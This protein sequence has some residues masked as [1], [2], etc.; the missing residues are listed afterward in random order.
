MPELGS[1]AGKNIPKVFAPI[2]PISKAFHRLPQTLSKEA[3]GILDDLLLNPFAKDITEK[4]SR[5]I[6]LTGDSETSTPFDNARWALGNSDSLMA[7]PVLQDYTKQVKNLSPPPKAH[8]ELDRKMSLALDTAMHTDDLNEA[9]DAFVKWA[10]YMQSV[11]QGDSDFFS[12]RRELFTERLYGALIGDK[13]KQL[14]KLYEEMDKIQYASGRNDRYFVDVAG[15]QK[16][17]LEEIVENRLSQSFIDD[18][19]ELESDFLISLTN[20]GLRKQEV[21][22]SRHRFGKM[23]DIEKAAFRKRASRIFKD[24]EEVLASNPNPFERLLLVSLYKLHSTNPHVTKPD[25]E[26]HIRGL[27]KNYYVSVILKYQENS[28]QIKAIIRDESDPWKREVLQAVERKLGLSGF[29]TNLDS[30]LAAKGVS[31]KYQKMLEKIDDELAKPLVSANV[32]DKMD[33]LSKDAVLAQIFDFEVLAYKW[34]RTVPIRSLVLPAKNSPQFQNILSF[35]RQWP[36][37]A[38]DLG[39]SDSDT[40]LIQSQFEKILKLGY[41]KWTFLSSS[42]PYQPLTPL[43]WSLSNSY[44]PKS[45]SLLRRFVSAPPFGINKG[46]LEAVEDLLGQRIIW[47]ALQSPQNEKIFNE[48]AVWALHVQSLGEPEK[49]IALLINFI[50]SL[51]KLPDEVLLALSEIQD[52]SQQKYLYWA[53]QGY[54]KMGPKEQQIAR[55]IDMLLFLLTQEVETTVPPASTIKR[56]TSI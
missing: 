33:W 56:Q 21:D 44:D 49:A 20:W 29:K 1:I 17:E 53:A 38:K 46:L 41:H 40:R 28:A 45:I 23:T 34:L 25:L 16:N 26:A 11:G 14:V 55:G 52:Q 37:T 3:Q 32:V 51:G 27:L 48:L 8:A 24:Q 19:M 54:R 39:V 35:L 31:G 30:V 43:S 6:D 18:F 36:Q 10:R 7:S 42:A 15:H 4:K 47:N 9:V 12:L 50:E 5:L 22:Q 2:S 13:Q